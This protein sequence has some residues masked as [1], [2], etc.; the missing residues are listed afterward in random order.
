M[1][2]PHT[3]ETA[4]KAIGHFAHAVQVG[5]LL[6]LSGQ[7]PQDPRTGSMPADIGQQTT[8]TLANL[9]RVLVACGSSLRHVV[10]VNVYLRDPSDFE[11]F[12]RAYAAAF[13]DHKP[14]RT[15]TCPDLLGDIL[16]EI[17]CVAH[18]ELQ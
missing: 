2:T 7:G 8:A 9:E 3:V 15:T 6:Y 14:A 13:G 12:N 17:D 4:P 16:V 11:T 5:D 10:K 1:L 18:V